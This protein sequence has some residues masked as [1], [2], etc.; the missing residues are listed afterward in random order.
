MSLGPLLGAA[1]AWR[2]LSPASRTAEEPVHGSPATETGGPGQVPLSAV[3]HNRPALLSMGAYAAHAWETLGLRGW[4]SA[5]LAAVLVQAGT[6]LEQATSTGA[7]LAGIATVLGAVGVVTVGAASDRLGR[8]QTIALVSGLSAVLILALGL[9]LTLPWA[10]VVTVTLLAAFLVNADSAVI[11][12]TLTESVPHEILGRV[13]G[14]YSFLGFTAGALAPLT[15]GAVLDAAT[16]A[17]G[18]G[19]TWAF[20]TLSISS[21]VVL[22]TAIALH[23]E[24]RRT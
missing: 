16:S 20:G 13:L 23:R 2:T 14:V 10:L 12:T 9:V 8:T 6:G 22:A 4:L 17:T 3:L 18:S 5:F 11:S 19:W 15:F 24:L 7:T 21:L 1:I